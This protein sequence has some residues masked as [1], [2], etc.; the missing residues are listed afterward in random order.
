MGLRP[1]ATIS[2]KIDGEKFEENA[3]GDGQ[4]D[5]FMNALSRVYTR[6]K[7][8]LP[9]L[10]DYAVRIAHYA[11]PSSPGKPNRKNSSPVALIPTKRYAPL[12]LRRRCWILFEVSGWRLE[13]SAGIFVNTS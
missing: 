3:Q 8:S 13:I 11:K 7:R 5:A 6:K 4:F 1:S 9:K 2:V 10:I 12:R